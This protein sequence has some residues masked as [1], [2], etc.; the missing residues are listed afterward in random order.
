MDLPIQLYTQATTSHYFSA[1]VIGVIQVTPS[2]RGLG[3]RLGDS[4]PWR[5]ASKIQIAC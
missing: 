2:P 5:V 1:H 3:A 4:K